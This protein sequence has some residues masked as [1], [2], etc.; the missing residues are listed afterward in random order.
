[1][2][3][4]VLQD[5]GF[6]YLRGT[7]RM[8]AIVFIKQSSY[9]EQLA[10]T[11]RPLGDHLATSGYHLATTWLPLGDHLATTW[12]PLGYH[13]ATTWLPLGNHLATT[14]LPLGD[15]FLNSCASSIIQKNNLNTL[16]HQTHQTF[17]GY[18]I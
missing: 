5:P 8:Q 13:L 2:T 3:T 16:F 1:M 7:I 12:Q 15:H 18:H 10:T 6:T 14:W 11:W 9:R 4:H 17:L